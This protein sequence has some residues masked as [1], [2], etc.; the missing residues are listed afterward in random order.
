MKYNVYYFNFLAPVHFGSGSLTDY[1]YYLCADTL[2]SALCQESLCMGGEEQLEKLVHIVKKGNLLFSDVMPHI[3]KEMWIPKPLCKVRQ[4]ESGN[5]ILKKNFKKLKY[6]PLNQIEQYLN[7]KLDPI[8]ENKKM[9]ELGCGTVRTKATLREK[10]EALPYDIGTYIFTKGNGLYS[11]IGY[12]DAADIKL[13][14]QLLFG[15]GCTGIG[16][17]VSSGYGKFTL[18]KEALSLEIVKKLENGEGSQVSL[19]S[20]MACEEELE[21]VL[22]GAQYK[23]LKRSGFISSH[24]YAQTARKKK[25]FYVFQSGS[26]F[27][28]TFEGDIF[29]VSANG[30][31]P[32]YR[33]AKPMFL[34]VSG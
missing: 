30:K 11:I 12:E 27:Q 26:C 1:N 18:E 6:I 24:T 8:V 19:S 33:Y 25:D 20:S 9:K 21:K 34:E 17:K 28:H 13:I 23:L 15:L 5:S 3:K 32:V 4:E 22:V 2:F 31:H 29:D 16:G 14:E 10:E 7:G